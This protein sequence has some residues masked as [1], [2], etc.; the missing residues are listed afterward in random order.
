MLRTARAAGLTMRPQYR[1]QSDHWLPNLDRRSPLGRLCLATRRTMACGVQSDVERIERRRYLADQAME[2][3]NY[4]DSLRNPIPLTTI[5]IFCRSDGLPFITF[6]ADPT[7]HLVEAF[8]EGAC[9]TLIGQSVR[10]MTGDDRNHACPPS[11]RPQVSTIERGEI[12]YETRHGRSGAN[13][14]ISLFQ[15]GFAAQN[16]AIIVFYQAQDSLLPLMQ[17]PRLNGTFARALLVTPGNDPAS[18]RA[19]KVVET[20]ANAGLSKVVIRVHS[21]QSEEQVVELQLHQDY[22]TEPINQLLDASDP[23][24]AELEAAAFLSRTVELIINWPTG[25]NDSRVQDLETSLGRQER[26]QYRKELKAARDYA[27]SR[28]DII[29]CTYSNAAEAS[30]SRPFNPDV[31]YVDKSA[32]AT[33]L[34][35]VIAFGHYE[36]RSIILVGDDM[37]LRPVAK[38]LDQ[39]DENGRIVNCFAPQLMLSPFK[40]LKL[41][42]YPSCLLREQHRMAA[43]ISKLASDLVYHGLL[44]DAPETALRPTTMM[45]TEIFEDIYIFKK[46][47]HALRDTPDEPGQVPNLEL[48]KRV[49]IIAQA[50]EAHIDDRYPGTLPVARDVAQAWGLSVFTTSCMAHSLGGGLGG[51]VVFGDRRK[52]H[53]LLPF[54][55]LRCDQAAQQM[56]LAGP[57]PVVL[58]NME[59]LRSAFETV[60]VL[61]GQATR[62]RALQAIRVKKVDC[63]QGG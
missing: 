18:S 22:H 53:A 49:Q 42:G 46:I 60:T 57:V 41:L 63:Y 7:A 48:A 17:F 30:L 38:S 36:P 39:K 40:R 37:Q 5:F 19:V 35:L 52:E 14:V 50:Y 21:W 56:T 27:L 55:A 13:A 25:V 12:S 28:A 26:Q 31:L 24:T 3:H 8:G 6:P 4:R 16:L 62:N 33:E 58:L 32:R 1:E 54:Q 10:L 43:G 2:Y 51:G 45:D 23:L 9:L 34:D 59:K 15:F 47:L 61:A 11:Q 29:I 44:L 20:L